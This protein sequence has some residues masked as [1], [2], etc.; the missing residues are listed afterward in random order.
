MRYPHQWRGQP[1]CSRF[2]FV[3]S[4]P[5]SHMWGCTWTVGLC[6]SSLVRADSVDATSSKESPRRL[7][8]PGNYS[9][10]G[11]DV[12]REGGA[13]SWAGGSWCTKAKPLRE[14]HEKFLFRFFPREVH[15]RRDAGKQGEGPRDG[16]RELVSKPY[17]YS[18]LWLA[19]G[20][21]CCTMTSIRSFNEYFPPLRQNFALTRQTH[22]YVYITVKQ[23]TCRIFT[24]L[25]FV[26]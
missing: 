22:I 3:I 5:L 1:A 26:G 13:G 20:G 12:G 25:E 6:T 19:V 10:K 14:Q 16:V 11:S 18:H 7:A 17:C 2:I 15:N 21:A 8:C 24:V 23:H 4:P 9:S